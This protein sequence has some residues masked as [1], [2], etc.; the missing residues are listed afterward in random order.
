LFTH[1]RGNPSSSTSGDM[2]IV[3]LDGEAPIS[4]PTTGADSI[5]LEPGKKYR[6]ALIATGNSFTGLVYELSNTSVPIVA[7][8]AT[9]DTYA[10]GS[11]GLV[12][13]NNASETGFDGPADAT[14]DNFLATTAEPRLSVNVDQG[15]L[16]VSWPL[17]PFVLQSSLSLAT[18]AWTTISAGIDQVGS[19]NV[20]NV[21]VTADAQFY[22]LTYP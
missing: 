19:S 18:P 9:D 8:T 10:T 21:P 7:I 15:L 22:R 13:A 20:Y 6:F 16:S 12:V 17:I 11:S 1:D 3:R 4:L 5:H 2:D 14:F